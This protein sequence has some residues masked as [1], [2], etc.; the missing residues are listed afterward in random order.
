MKKN[1]MEG[2]LETAV[3]LL[4]RRDHSERQ[5]REKLRRKAFTP[6][7]IGET[8]SA[9]KDKGYLNDSKLGLQALE[10]LIGERRYG[11]RGITGKLRQIGLSQMSEN[12]VRQHYSEEDEWE[13]AQRILSKHF[14]VQDA[15]SFPRMMRILT[16][17]GFS[18]AIINKIAQ[19]C[20]KHQ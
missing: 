20:R 7:Q 2:P 5:M 15:A 1:Q 8:I 14:A 12:L 18:S 6:E 10:K 17:R 11:L 9:L 4:A 13:T 16:N 3:R 19:E